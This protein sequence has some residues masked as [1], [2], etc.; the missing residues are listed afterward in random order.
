V[1]PATPDPLG[2]RFLVVHRILIDVLFGIVIAESFAFLSSIKAYSEC[3]ADPIGHAETIAGLSLVYL[4]VITSWY[5]YHESTDRYPIRG[6]LRSAVDIGL[7]FLYYI[8]FRSATDLG[9]IIP[10]FRYVFVGY[11]SWDFLRIVEYRKDYR[12]NAPMRK[13]HLWSMVCTLIFTS[14]SAS[15][16]YVFQWMMSGIS[17]IQWGYFVALIGFLLGYRQ[18][19]IWVEKQFPEPPPQLD[20]SRI[21]QYLKALEK[22]GEAY[23]REQQK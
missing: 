9:S 20:L 1:S 18:A 10:L 12:K 23:E 21:K 19:K 14:V 8:M 7:I 6:W 4:L 3:I 17:G 13:T 5:A 16:P 2:S 22:L 11:L 15:L